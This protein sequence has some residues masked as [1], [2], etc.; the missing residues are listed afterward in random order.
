MRVSLDVRSKISCIFK[1]LGIWILIFLFSNL[2]G[3]IAGQVGGLICAMFSIQIAFTVLSMLTAVTLFRD[4]YRYLMGLK[5]TFK[6]M[7][8]VVAISLISALPLT[9]LTNIL[10]PTSH[11]IQVS[12]QLLIPM[13]L[14]LAPIGEELLF[15]GL[16][17][18]C[19]MR[20][21][22]RWRSIMIS[23]TIFALIHL[24]AFSVYSETL[25]TMF[26]IFAGAFT[27]GVIA[28]H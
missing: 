8:K 19:L 7:V 6:S 10:A 2:I 27:L 13:V 21:I 1:A 14:I 20:C 16:L 5:F 15:R 28:G 26:L 23:S 9:Y 18:G 4:E 3:G 25:L 24:P 17:L 12:I 11:Q 22:S